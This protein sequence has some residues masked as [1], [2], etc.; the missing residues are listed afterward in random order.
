MNAEAHIARK[1]AAQQALHALPI[2]ATQHARIAADAQVLVMRK[3]A[4]EHA[5]VHAACL[6]PLGA[7]PS[8]SVVIP[9]PRDRD[10]QYAAF[11]ALAAPLVAHLEA[12]AADGRLPQIIVP[13]GS[14]G[15]NLEFVAMR[16]CR[17]E[18]ASHADPALTGRMARLG[19]QLAFLTQRR[20]TPGQQILHTATGLL[21]EHFCFGQPEMRNEHLAS[22]LHWLTW[23]PAQQGPLDE[24]LFYA[25]LEDI[26]R[27]QGTGAT[28]LPAFDA[29]LMPAFRRYVAAKRRRD[30]TAMAAA[31]G[32][33]TGGF[34]TPDGTTVPG[35]AADVQELYGLTQRAVAL[36]RARGLPELLRAG[37][38]LA[39]PRGT[40]SCTPDE[41]REDLLP[42]QQRLRPER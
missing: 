11:Q 3:M 33:L 12:C 7:P 16:M 35:M 30:R 26:E 14:H 31:E 6:G 23:A 13:S 2:A 8:V 4:S 37:G 1:I 28:P 18:G 41:A 19:A 24:E 10:R 21:C 22:L 42:T 9:D 25:T 36:L 40:P 5:T 29:A 38:R 39:T 34:T 32:E 20:H 17:A 27:R 15:E